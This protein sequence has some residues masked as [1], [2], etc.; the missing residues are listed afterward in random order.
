MDAML[1]FYRTLG[2]SF[3]QEQHGAGSMHHSCD[4][5]GT[6]LE[7]YPGTESSTL[8]WRAGGATMLGFRAASVDVVVAALEQSGAHVLTPSKDLMRGRRAV[9]ADPDGCAVELSQ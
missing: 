8:D 1:A 4:L 7:I 9:V 5:G 3:S 2:M 6:V